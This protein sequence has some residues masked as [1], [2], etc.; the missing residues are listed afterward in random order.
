[1]S[2]AE[3]PPHN[4]KI[5]ILANKTDY[6]YG[7]ALAV[8]VHWYGLMEGIKKILV[9][10]DLCLFWLLVEIILVWIRVVHLL[11]GQLMGFNI[12]KKKLGK[13]YKYTTGKGH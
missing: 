3:P 8:F 10:F 5:Y 13:H 4:T 9:R 7:A 2:I 11:I 6:N 1:M 12:D